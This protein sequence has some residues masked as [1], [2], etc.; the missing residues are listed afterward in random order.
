MA[1]LTD[2]MARYRR[3]DELKP[4]SNLREIKHNALVKI[5]GTLS[6]YELDD[7]YRQS[8]GNY[9]SNVLLL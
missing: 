2:L 4:V 7:A 8:T 3:F 1:D 9:N 6:G 5:S